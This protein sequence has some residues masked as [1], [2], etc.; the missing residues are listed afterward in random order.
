MTAITKRDL[1]IIARLA[2]RYGA[3]VVAKAAKAKSAGTRGRPADLDANALAVWSHVEHR[4][5][6]PNGL[7]RL[8]VSRVCELLAADLKKWTLGRPLSA[9]R[10]RALYGRAAMLREDSAEWR[11]FADTQLE[12]LASIDQKTIPLF[13]RRNAD[14]SCATTILDRLGRGGG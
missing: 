7:P 9:K 1:A 11:D 10:L 5:L 6:M 8:S 13:L 12:T 2:A 3:A 4:R 14:G